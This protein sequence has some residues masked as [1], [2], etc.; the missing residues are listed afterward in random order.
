[1][2]HG[3][4]ALVRPVTS[5][6]LVLLTSVSSPVFDLGTSGAFRVLLAWVPQETAA[7]FDP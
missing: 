3:L 6:M 1:M 5:P 2:R 7:P 4:L